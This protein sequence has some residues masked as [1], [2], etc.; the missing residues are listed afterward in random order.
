MLL[1]FLSRIT[2]VNPHN[3]FRLPKRPVCLMLPLASGHSRAELE[4]LNRIRL[5]RASKA[6]P[7]TTSLLQPHPFHKLMIN[8]RQHQQS[9]SIEPRSLMSTSSHLMKSLMSTCTRGCLCALQHKQ[10]ASVHPCT[11]PQDKVSIPVVYSPL[12]PQGLIFLTNQT[13]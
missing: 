6:H 13:V 10:N 2:A 3:F 8:I 4:K 7:M 12:K 9:S 5:S 11:V 1:F